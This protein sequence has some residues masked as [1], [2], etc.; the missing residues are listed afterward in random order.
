M[1]PA[2]RLAA[3]CALTRGRGR[4]VWR[5]FVQICKGLAALHRLNILHRG[6]WRPHGVAHPKPDAVTAPRARPPAAADLKS[7]NCFLSR[8]E[9]VKIGDFNVS[10]TLKKGLAHTQIGTPY[11]MRWV[12]ADC[13]RHEGL[14]PRG[15][16]NCSRWPVAA[17]KYGAIGPTTPRA[18][19]GQ[20]A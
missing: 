13:G 1:R 15:G 4:S 18:T 12:A 14:A 20:P 11:Y 19:C 2:A 10:R 6:A 9:V 16:T 3:T 5:Y 17:P 8:E 7:A